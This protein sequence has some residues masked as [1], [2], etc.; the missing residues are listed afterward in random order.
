MF[1]RYRLHA[2]RAKEC[3]F[4]EISIC[5][6]TKLSTLRDAEPVLGEAEPKS[7]VLAL[8]ASFLGLPFLK[9]TSQQPAE[10]LESCPSGH[11]E[12]RKVEVG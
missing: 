1:G 10:T 9:Q 3:M 8:P 5:A 4:G 11:L 7:R 6:S 2:R 12:L